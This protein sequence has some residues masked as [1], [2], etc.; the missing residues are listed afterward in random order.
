MRSADYLNITYSKTTVA[1]MWLFSSSCARFREH[2]TLSHT[3]NNL[4]DVLEK[5]LRSGLNFPSS[6]TRLKKI[7]AMVEINVVT[8]LEEMMPR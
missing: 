2:E 4:W 5:M 1:V 3:I 7:K 6:N 8:L